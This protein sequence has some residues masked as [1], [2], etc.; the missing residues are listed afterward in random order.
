[1]RLKLLTILVAALTW[2][3]TCAAADYN[4]EAGD[5]HEITVSEPFYFYD[6]GGP[7]GPITQN[8]SG[9]VTFIPATDGMAVKLNAEEFATAA[10]KMM[11]YSG[12][13]IDPERILGNTTGYFV[14]KGPQ[15]LV[16]EA[17]DGSVTIQFT[18]KG[19]NLKGWKIAVSLVEKPQPQMEPM[20]GTYIVGP[21][22]ESRFKTLAELEKALTAGIG[23]PVTILLEEHVFN[24]N[25][26]ISSIEGLS[27]A[28][29]LTVTSLSGNADATV[30]AG[31]A[32][33][34]DRQGTVCVDN[35][36][37]VTF[38]NITVSAPLGN[39]SR[40]PY[41]ALQFC[42]GSRNG[43]IENCVVKA[44]MTSENDNRTYVIMVNA[45]ETATSACD[46]LSI[47][48]NRIE[49][50]YIG[51]YAGVDPDV[52]GPVTYG[53]NICD[54]MILNTNL[55]GAQLVECNG[56]DFTGNTI[57]PGRTGKKSASHL[58]VNAPSGSFR[59]VA[60]KILCEQSTDCSGL[61]L[62]G[63]G[64]STDA[65][66]PGLVVNNVVSIPNATN[67]YT[68]GIMVDAAMTNV[69]I[70]HNSINIVGSKSLKNVYGIAFN[71][72][73]APKGTAPS[74][75]NNIVRN[76]TAQGPLRPWN[77]SHYANLTFQGNVYFGG[78]DVVDCDGNSME[79]YREA[80]GDNSS[81]WLE[82]EFMSDT[83]LHL[84]QAD[85]VMAMMRNRFVTTDFDGNER[86]DPTTAGAYEFAFPEIERPTIAEGYPR[87]ANITDK[88]VEITTRW[89]VGGNLY[90]Q[91][92]P[93]G[94]AAPE[95]T[96]LKALEPQAIDADK[97][98]PSRF[99]GLQ[100]A[101]DYKA[102]FLVVSAMNAESE[103][104]ASATFTT[105]DIIQ[106]LAA[107]IFWDDEP[108]NEGETVELM[109]AVIGGLEPY[110]YAWTD[111]AGTPR[112]NDEI[113]SFTAAVN[114]T[115]HLSVKSADGQE[116]SCK[117]HVPVVTARPAI[118]SF[119]DL[120]LEPESNW[121]W[122]QQLSSGG[123][124]QDYFF[125]G[126]YKFGNFSM[127]S[128]NAW[129]GYGYSNETSTSFVYLDDQMRNVVGGGAANTA[130]Y[131]V[132]Y[133]YGIDSRIFLSV[134]DEGVEIPGIYI[135]NSAYTLNSILSGDSFNTKFTT[136]DYQTLT[137]EGLNGSESTGSVNVALADYR[138]ATPYV[139]T[140][141]QWVDLSPLGKIT[142]LRLNLDGNKYTT[143]P[144]YVCFDEIG[145]ENPRSAIDHIAADSMA[146]AT[147]TMFGSNLAVSG[148]D[149]MYTLR[150]FSVDGI[151]RK[152]LCLDG[153][154]AVSV[155]DLAS[156]TYIATITTA[157]G[158]SQSLRFIKR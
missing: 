86:P 111:Q 139:L 74:I 94:T 71:S 7:N 143:V 138:G 133:L 114:G 142:A 28:N 40:T 148:I 10:G 95:A 145:A 116:V 104:V 21:S 22:N 56:F 2:S 127:T 72:N 144:A 147:I 90:A 25:F 115:Y 67:S 45:G 117:A 46:N 87:A 91:A 36:P 60:N 96:T 8:F 103:I 102:Y 23:A 80:T 130:S 49:G 63:G 42:N 69:V 81:I 53:M 59:I 126:S 151:L 152:H 61:Y 128:A 55:R 120:A 98:I 122:D 154:T 107:E 75:I 123:A 85:R 155:A 70:A 118:A 16:S 100:P 5:G 149:G 157:S 64:G 15:D 3:M 37:F 12:R 32:T 92:V 44:P 121:R 9:S 110:T 26:M 31:S 129:F 33:V 18:G 43:S 35:S 58:E 135:T 54:N 84:R 112:G 105:P 62:R 108:V 109:A 66:H 93:A 20:A 76:T 14:S 137:I 141:W 125:S 24:E 41:A 99:T 48:G 30:I 134:P 17:D 13:S 4:M 150:I 153:A 132:G 146:S 29:T 101:T 65:A 50:G 77:S 19:I 57:T 1:M 131:G 11:I 140:Q 83:D 27:E 88:S 124:F 68:Y 158:S 52:D 6:D 97:D 82:A 38:R 73:A 39:G 79:A 156:G 89:S 34:L 51:I 106:P 113:L 136:G 47:R 119:E 78:G